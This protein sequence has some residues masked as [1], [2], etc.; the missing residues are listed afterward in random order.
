MHECSEEANAAICDSV[1]CAVKMLCMVHMHSGTGVRIMNS[2][3]LS[4]VQPKLDKQDGIHLCRLSLYT[5]M[6]IV[7]LA[8]VGYSL[9]YALEFI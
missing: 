4:Y 8:I 5:Q 7:L 2:I 3:K 1:I 6:S 9:S